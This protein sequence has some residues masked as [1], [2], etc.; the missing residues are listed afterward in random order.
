MIEGVSTERTPNQSYETGIGYV[1]VP[2]DVDRDNFVKTCCRKERLDI[3]L[4]NGGGVLM[5]CAIDR[6]TLQEIAFPKTYKELGSCV[7]YV[8]DRFTNKPIIVGVLSKRNESQLLDENAFKKVVRD[9]AGIVSVEGK[10]KGG[11][12]F[13]N[14]ESD[15][16]N[17]GSIFVT[18]KSKNNTSK[19]NVKCFGDI[20]IYAEGNAS[21][22]TLETAT[23]TSSYIDGKYKK[24]ASKLQLSHDGLLYEDKNENSVEIKDE[25]VNIKPKTKLNVFE[26]GSPMVLGDKLKSELNKS[27]KRMD[28]LLR[29]LS[30][31]LAMITTET[32]FQASLTA[33]ISAITDKED[34]SDIN[35]QKSFLD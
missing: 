13:I 23:V 19:F 25:T 22:E 15:F 4:D 17:G 30:T 26:G 20:E 24:M 7:V 16:E 32:A 27:K 34:Y 29:G 21:L 10:A 5:N 6:S 33:S 12:M 31:A 8:C 14:V 3:Q 35:S 2:S 28:D 11:N 1:V 9:D 18:L